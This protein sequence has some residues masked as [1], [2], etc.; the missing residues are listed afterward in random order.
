M[1]SRSIG[2]TAPESRGPYRYQSL[3]SSMSIRL[4]SIIGKDESGTLHVSLRVVNLED[5]PFYYA[6]SYTWGN[7]HANGVDFT[8][9][10]NEV[11]EQYS[12]AR[13]IPVFCDGRAIH[14][15]KNL[16][17]VLYE[18]KDAHITGQEQERGQG[19]LSDSSSSL[20]PGFCIWIDA[21]CINQDDFEERAIQVKLMDEI[22]RKASKTIV[23]LGSEDQWSTNAAKVVSRIAAYPRDS[24][25]ESEVAPFRN[26]DSV[27]YERSNLAYTSWMDWCSLAALLK[28]QWFS[29]LWI[30]QETILS[31]RLVL[32]C[33]KQQVL[34]DEFVSAVRN[35]EARC[36]VLG[37]S[38]STMFI[39]ASQPAVPLEHNALKL[40]TWR[41]YH[42]NH[43]AS[44]AWRST[45]EDLIYDTWV[46]VA[47]NPRDKIY[48]IL[49][50]IDPE[51]RAIWPVEYQSSIEEVY[52]IAARRII[53]TRQ[54]LK[55]L[56]CVQDASLRKIGAYP[57]WIPDFSLP[58]FNMMC[59]AGFYSAAGK[60]VNN[61]TAQVL[62]SPSG[63]WSRLR[64][65]ASV[66]DT[67]V[68]TGEDRTSH[69]NSAVILDP[70][71]FELALLLKTPYPGTGQRRT[72][73]LWRT[74]CADQDASSTINPAPAR[75]ADLF[76]EL[77]SAMV[78]VRA[79]IEEEASREPDPAP[80]CA[81]S[82]AQAMNRAKEMWVRVGWDK[83][84]PAEIY[85]QTNS[86][87]RLLWRPEYGWLSYTLVKLQALA[88]TEQGRGADTP[89]WEELETFYENPSYVMRVV[90]G[91]DK[92]LAQP[93]DA[94]FFN[95]F[96]R[97]Y[98]KRKLFITEK[99]YLG[100]GPASTAVGDVVCI[101]PG[102]EGPFVFRRDKCGGLELG[103][104]DIDI[105][106]EEVKRLRLVGESYIHGIM[107]GEA[108][109]A[110]GVS[111]MMEEIEIV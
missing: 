25:V 97:R 17:D 66:V 108:L 35:I 50:L 54:S 63:S 101:L 7:P 40:A 15:Q 28:R 75:F 56:S 73:V 83:L 111:V 69:I 107:H 4:L 46:F 68:E 99:G 45:L 84:S 43:E 102:A 59:N 21:I 98:A 76:K 27:V 64:L 94:S 11:A 47:T 86:R 52:A 26:Q 48:G 58:Y 65:R 2:E 87:P 33:G 103:D 14:V 96:R 9:Y 36:K 100:L 22:Y 85:D 78:V 57:S 5:D 38:P 71:W 67:I 89:N 20:Q 104:H 29:R 6:L 30:I 37:W 55:I 60:H 105:E 91:R 41:E 110:E 95:S 61:R 53:E 19:P 18:L 31:R 49:G 77:V 70:S 92:S 8:K 23:W 80:D 79:E 39:E 3:P 62:P 44:R 12:V 93:N 42:R 88:V 32:L 82:F 81:T 13:R 109:E 106:C 34:W 72:E 1:E 24:F 16:L 74:L 10:F 90:T 51:T